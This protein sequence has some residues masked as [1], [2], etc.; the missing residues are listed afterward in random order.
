MSPL[1]KKDFQQLFKQ[2]NCLAA[3]KTLECIPWLIGLLN[4]KSGN[5][6]GNLRWEV[7]RDSSAM[8]KSKYSIKTV[9][10]SDLYHQCEI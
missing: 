4:E 1:Y 2:K 6:K 9:S 10:A 3:Q 8:K 5:N 7:R